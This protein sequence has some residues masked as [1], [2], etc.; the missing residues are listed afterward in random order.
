[1]F[2]PNAEAI[3]ALAQYLPQLEHWQT[4]RPKYLDREQPDWEAKLQKAAQFNRYY[5]DWTRDYRAV[6]PLDV[7]QL[8]SQIRYGYHEFAGYLPYYLFLR[9]EKEEKRYPAAA[10]LEILQ[11]LHTSGL[12]RG[13]PDYRSQWAAEAEPGFKNPTQAVQ[14]M[15]LE[16]ISHF[17]SASVEQ[18][19]Y[20]FPIQKGVF[21][22]AIRQAVKL[23]S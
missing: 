3:R 16:T 15:D 22:A 14:G 11:A 5:Q 19:V 2:K 7:G 17:I 23:V 18:Q 10:M 12:L 6:K 8:A 9:K 13:L 4:E 1:M 20:S 21:A